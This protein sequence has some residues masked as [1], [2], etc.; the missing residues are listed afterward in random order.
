MVPYFAPAPA[1]FGREFA[2]NR[3]KASPRSLRIPSLGLTAARIWVIWSDHIS[4]QEEPRMVV[5]YLK[6]DGLTVEIYRSQTA[7]VV[8][9]SGSVSTHALRVIHTHRY[10]ITATA[11]IRY[12]IRLSVKPESMQNGA[13]W[14]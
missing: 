5:I 8:W 13:L 1:R 6:A 3:Y 2:E 4:L 12:A 9:R 14:H 7:P 10:N 11:G